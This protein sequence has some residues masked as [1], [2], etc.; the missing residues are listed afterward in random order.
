MRFQGRFRVSVHDV[1][2]VISRY[3]SHIRIWDA[4]A[5]GQ[6]SAAAR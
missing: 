3:A 2:S 1:C 6:V 4:G 5:E